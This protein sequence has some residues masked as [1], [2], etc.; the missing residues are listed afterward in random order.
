VLVTGA[1]GFLGTEC[2]RQ[3]QSAGHEV[4]TTDRRGAPDI[5]VDLTDADAVRQLPDVDAVVHSA[6]VQYVADDLPLIRRARYFHLNNVVATR[7]LAARYGETRTH[8]VNV[9]SS[10]MYE[11]THAGRYD[12]RSP[13]KPQGVY[14]ASKIEAQREIDRLP[15]PTAC[16]IPCIIAGTGR[17]GLFASLVRSMTQRGVAFWPGPGRHKIHLVHVEDAAAL[18]TTIVGRRATGRFNA[19]SREPLSIVEWVR[20][21][22]AALRLRRV[23]ELTLPLAPIALASALSGYRLLAREQ[24]LMLRFPHVLATE[25]SVALGWTPRFTNADIVRDTALALAGASASSPLTST[26]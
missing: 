2:V 13:W 25:E 14:T 17:G 4:I 26:N 12:V 8:F 3:L 6:A 18:I 22:T 23:R 24:V 7:Q 20:E 9:G 5:R 11:Q 1:V 16:V 19:A 15:G 10:M 21:M